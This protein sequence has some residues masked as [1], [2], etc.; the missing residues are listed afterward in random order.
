MDEPLIDNEITEDQIDSYQNTPSIQVKHGKKKSAKYTQ[1]HFVAFVLTFCSYAL[2]HATRKTISN[3]KYTLAD[4]WSPTNTTESLRFAYDYDQWNSHNLF[5][6]IK[7]AT[8][9]LGL[10]DLLFLLAYSAGLFLIGIIGDRFNLRYVLASGMIGSALSVFTF[11]CLTTW[12]N[13]YSVWFYGVIWCLNGFLQATGWPCVV[14]VIGT[15][16]GRSSR[17]LVL[18]I[19]SANASFGNIIGSYAVGGILKYGFE[20]AFFITS[21][22]LFAGGIVIYFG[23]LTTPKEVG[24]PE[25]NEGHKL[26]SDRLAAYNSQAHLI[27]DDG[28]Y[29]DE[30]QPKETKALPFL[31]VVMLPGVIPYSLAY[32][33]LKPVNYAFFFWLP[34]YLSSKYHWKN[35]VADN[36]STWY[37]F[38]GIIE[39]NVFLRLNFNE[40]IFVLGGIVFGYISKYR[41]L[42]PI[43]RYFFP[44]IWP[45]IGSAGDMTVQVICG[46]RRKSEMCP[47]DS[48]LNPTPAAESDEDSDNEMD[49]HTPMDTITP[50]MAQ[51]Y[52]DLFHDDTENEDFDGFESDED[53]DRLKFRSPVMV[54]MI[55][56]S[57]ITLYFYQLSPNNKLINSVLMGLIGIFLNG[58]SSIL[59]TAVTADLGRQEAI[60]SNE[61]A[62]GTVTGI[63]DGFASFSAA[64]FQI[65]VPLIN[66]KYGW[67]VLFYVFMVMT[68]LALVALI[69]PLLRD[70]KE[71]KE[72]RR[73][74]HEY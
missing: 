24:L 25:A 51:P 66:E 73:L 57:P 68:I 33:C 7:S 43:T 16:F 20:Y 3:T 2:Y 50:E 31:K 67:K 59:S 60:K 46:F 21:T 40:I 54:L 23:L 39:I 64:I 37:D 36:L 53:R 19:W 35:S 34:Y 13:Y 72:K 56:I 74:R 11:G 48:P 38:G 18:G 52:Y 30:S 69:P 55:I 5:P 32:A 12:T 42:R 29:F 1:H 26:V 65:C 70:F 8:V 58:A 49:T 6:N 62:L 47:E 28:N 10:L 15:W 44:K 17:G 14:A 45:K 27:D 61:T 71:W 4:Y 41:I 22:M 9:Y 63:I